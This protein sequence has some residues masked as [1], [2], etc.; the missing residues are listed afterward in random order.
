MSDSDDSEDEDDPEESEEDGDGLGKV[1]PDA[2]AS[3]ARF[4]RFVSRGESFVPRS[5]G[6]GRLEGSTSGPASSESEEDEAEDD[7]E[8]E[9]AEVSVVDTDEEAGKG[10]EAGFTF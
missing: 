8:E 9:L 4:L 2:D 10:M 3:R 7:E 1:G 5:A 6:S